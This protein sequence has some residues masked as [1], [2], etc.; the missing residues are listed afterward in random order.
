MEDFQ[1]NNFKIKVIILMLLILMISSFNLALAQDSEQETNNESE[2]VYI[3]ADHLKY[4]DEKTILTGNIVIRKEQTTIKANN[5][6][7]MREENKF[8]LTE[9]IDVDYE[10]GQVT[11]NNLT[12]LLKEEEYV[13]ENNVKMD[14]ILENNEENM[15]LESQYLKIF[16]DNKS[17]NAKNN[18]LIKYEGKNFK[19]DNAE[20]VGEEEI[21]YLTGNVMIEEGE[22]WVKSDQ[23]KFFLGE[24]EGGYTADGNVKIKM[25]L[26]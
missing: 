8:Y 24:D 15:K 17:F 18:V 9:N 13:F 26:E 1:M 5:G 21:L 12:A 2:T 25:I 22:D 23:A 7:L 4:E 11:S 3:D 10:D 19:G 6:E 16:G 14:Y 20:Y